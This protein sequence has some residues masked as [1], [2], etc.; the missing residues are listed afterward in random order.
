M[1]SAMGWTWKRARNSLPDSISERDWKREYHQ[2]WDGTKTL[3]DNLVV[4]EEDAYFNAVTWMTPLP[5]G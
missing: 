4:R 5:W 2:I 1:H 3:K